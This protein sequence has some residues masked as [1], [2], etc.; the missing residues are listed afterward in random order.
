MSNP[1]LTKYGY[2]LILITDKKPS[3]LAFLPK[4]EYENAII[5]LSKKSVRNKLRM[6]ASNYDS[7][8]LKA[9]N[10]SFN[11]TIIDSL[12]DL[13]NKKNEENLLLGS[14]ARVDFFEILHS[15]SGVVCVYNNK[16]FGGKWFANKMKDIPLTQLPFF[17]SSEDI[18]TTFTTI[19]LQ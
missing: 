5:N 10:L 16:G 6:A 14:S 15:I 9:A 11:F 3:D 8:Q 17:N 18:I 13:Y 7:L 19:I 2:H 4:K 1:V 12:I